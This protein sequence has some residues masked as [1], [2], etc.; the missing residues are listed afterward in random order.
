[1]K[2]LFLC[3]RSSLLNLSIDHTEDTIGLR[4]NVCLRQNALTYSALIKI[5]TVKMFIEQL[6]SLWE[7][8]RQQQAYQGQASLKNPI[9]RSQCYKNIFV[10]NLRIFV[11][12]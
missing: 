5:T 6:L 3:K 1:M 10:R 12:S 2:F 7:D 8:K 4:K 11:L 9:S